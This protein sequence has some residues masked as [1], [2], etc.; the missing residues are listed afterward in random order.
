[1]PPAERVKPYGTV[2]AVLAAKDVIT[3]PF[4]VIN[5][6]DY[7][8]KDAF[9][10]MGQMFGGAELYDSASLLAL[11]NYAPI[12]L[13]GA[14][15]ATPLPKILGQ[16]LGKAKVFTVL[17][18]VLLAVVLLLCTSCLIDGSFNPFIYFRF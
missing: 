11:R 9:V 10:T 4:A 15:G 17:E 14:I 16:K 12:L 8:G 13:I 18:P 5:A 3:E 7:Y 2:H 1:M 6:D